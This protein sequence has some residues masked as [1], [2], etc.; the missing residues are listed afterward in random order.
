MARLAA[1]AWLGTQDLTIGL[2][3]KGYAGKASQEVLGMDLPGCL[4]LLITACQALFV[5]AA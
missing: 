2:G 5:V 1:A 3:G 4:A